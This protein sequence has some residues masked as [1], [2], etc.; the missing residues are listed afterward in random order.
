MT[1]EQ[2]ARTDLQSEIIRKIKAHIYEHELQPGDLLPS[3]AAMC[4]MLGASRPSVREAIKT[5]EAQGLVRSINGKGIY[6][7]Q[8]DTSF[9]TG[10]SSTAYN[11]RLLYDALAVRKAL[12]GMAV[13]LCIENASD[14][15]LRELSGILAQVEDKYYRK[16]HQADLDLLYHKTLIQL[17]GNSLLSNMLK[18]L[19]QHS[20]GLWSMKD[21]VADIL[22]DSI[23]SHRVVMDLMLA[24]NTEQ[25]V[26]EHNGYKIGRAHV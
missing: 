19:M 16:E 7:E 2:I 5:M 25:A 17:A 26:K 8:V 13:E 14:E 11:I 10:L 6:V 21:V 22:N 12:E 20:S 15:Q 23:P 18:N 4:A 1:I 3:Q 24:R 9:H